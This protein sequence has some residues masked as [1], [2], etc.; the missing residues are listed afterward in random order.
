MAHP[1]IAP[2]ILAADILNLEAEVTAITHAGADWIHVDVMDGHYVP[3]L[4]FGPELVRTLKQKTT[5]PLDIHLMIQPA[6]PYIEAFA[7]AGASVITV[8]PDSDIHIHRTLKEIRRHGI[9]AGLALNPGVS[10]D[11]LDYL[12]PEID[13]ILVMTVNPGFGGQRFISEMLPKIKAVQEK[14]KTAPHPIL[15]E[16]DGGV[17]PEIVPNLH[18]L[19]VDVL[20]AG[21]AI[22][23]K[24]K[25]NYK[26]TI[27]QLRGEL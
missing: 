11:V 27:R 26:N 15:I 21:S 2:S 9:K 14:I 25:N 20:V 8:H 4:S 12:L 23:A 3:N 13:L 5:L 7:K 22:F 10:L 16:V 6:A 24:G 1:L 18:Q 17:T 19:N